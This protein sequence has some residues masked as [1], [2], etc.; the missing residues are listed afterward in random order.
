MSDKSKLKSCPFCGTHSA[1][2][3]YTEQYD[4][5][6]V[7]CLECDNSTPPT[8]KMVRSREEAIEAWNG[9]WAH[10]RIAEL[11]KQSQREDWEPVELPADEKCRAIVARA[12]AEIIVAYRM[13][14]IRDMLN[15]C[16]RKAKEQSE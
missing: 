15:L 9:A 11:E 8:H 10:G 1:R 13:A 12:M 6:F 4:D 7:K 2:T 16:C 14:G 3:F 5:W